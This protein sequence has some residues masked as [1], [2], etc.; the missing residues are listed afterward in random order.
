MCVEF[1]PFDEGAV[2]RFDALDHRIE[3]HVRAPQVGRLTVALHVDVDFDVGGRTADLVD[4]DRT[5]RTTANVGARPVDEIVESLDVAAEVV[6]ALEIDVRRDDLVPR[7]MGAHRIEPSELVPRDDTVL[8]QQ[9]LLLETGEPGQRDV[10]DRFE[11]LLAVRA[12]R[13]LETFAVPVGRGGEVAVRREPL[14]V[15]V[16]DGETLGVELIVGREVE[17]R[18][19]VAGQI[20]PPHL[21]VTVD[22]RDASARI[23][24]T[25][26]EQDARGVGQDDAVARHR[27]RRAYADTVGVNRVAGRETFERPLERSPRGRR[28]RD[29]VVLDDHGCVDVGLVDAPH[30]H[31]ALHRGSTLAFAIDRQTRLKDQFRAG[32]HQRGRLL[33]ARRPRR[34]GVQDAQL[35]ERVAPVVLGVATSSIDFGTRRGSFEG[36]RR[37]ATEGH[38][39]H[40]GDNLVT[41]QGSCHGS[42][43]TTPVSPHYAS[44]ARA[45]RTRRSVRPTRRAFP[46]PRSRRR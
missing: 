27:G 8:A 1:T 5:K 10:I 13:A 43:P 33:G 20:E 18:I 24:V 41:T 38:S 6:L 28:L 45:T 23:G 22:H 9:E 31:E 39:V 40:A 30:A 4:V 16:H 35:L 17:T 29:L 21:A 44:S 12:K 15:S 32:D 42:K 11:L 7:H 37:A 25:E 46:I 3:R 34:P 26:G 2:A 36:E 14:V 19:V